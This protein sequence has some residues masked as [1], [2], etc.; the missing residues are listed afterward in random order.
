M[1]KGLIV[2]IVG[3]A[4]V[5]KDTFA[6]MLAEEL[7]ERT[8]RKFVLM[9]YATELKQRVQKDFDLS[10][11]QLW[12]DDKENIDPRYP[13]PCDVCAGGDDDDT[14]EYW[15]AREILQAYGQFY[16]TIDYDFWVKALFDTIE[17]KEYKDVIITDVRHPN[18]AD[19]VKG[20]AGVVIK[21]L[22]ARQGLPSIH[23]Q[24]HISEVAMDDYPVD[25][26]VN[27]D[28]GLPELRRSAKEI[29]ALITN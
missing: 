1:G 28:W 3:R 22:S 29:A 12:G 17:F 11:E 24:Q 15:T 27:N 9:A 6:E 5:G 8:K 10:Y 26:V 18:E 16:R 4:R 2:G 20:S 13:K 21:V 25:H 19:P 14:Q 7:Y 23:G